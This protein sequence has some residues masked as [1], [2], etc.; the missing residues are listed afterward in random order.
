MR[1]TSYEGS[2]FDDDPGGLLDFFFTGFDTEELE[3]LKT[4]VLQAMTKGRMTKYDVEEA[5]LRLFPGS[6]E[7]EL[8]GRWDKEWGTRRMPVAQFLSLCDELVERDDLL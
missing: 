6:S 5:R 2:A 7:V 4:W 3:E 1:V 8:S